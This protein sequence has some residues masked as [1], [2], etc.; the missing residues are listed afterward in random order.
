MSS[1]RL[2]SAHPQLS[3]QSGLLNTIDLYMDEV[4]SKKSKKRG[5]DRVSELKKHILTTLA[6]VE[7]LNEM[8]MMWR[9]FGY[10]CMPS[11]TGPLDTS[12]TLRAR[13]QAQLLRELKISKS[14]LDQQ[15]S[16]IRYHEML[17]YG[18][19]VAQQGASYIPDEA[20]ILNKAKRALLMIGLREHAKIVD[21]RV[22]ADFLVAL[23]EVL[24]EHK[25]MVEKEW[26]NGSRLA[27]VEN[28]HKAIG[29]WV[30]EEKLNDRQ[31]L[32]RLYEH[33]MMS[34][35]NEMSLVDG[36]DKLQMAITVEMFKHLQLDE[37]ALAEKVFVAVARSVYA[38]S[39]P[40]G[41][42][43][44]VVADDPVT[45]SLKFRLEAINTKLKEDTGVENVEIFERTG[46]EI[47]MRS[48]TAK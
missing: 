9:M 11:G 7:K 22:A 47:E 14:D 3:Y 10:T 42:A 18:A 34:S 39:A 46:G 20:S 33:L 17:A 2:F 45:L 27:L 31:V 30:M 26:F 13:I 32:A 43:G 8:Q 41:G 38:V 16:V 21:G 6:C 29:S 44:V 19:L 28:L 23:F 37:A 5:Y 25:Q 48:F 4:K 1:P 24:E 15:C 40:G 36:D 12:T 35:R